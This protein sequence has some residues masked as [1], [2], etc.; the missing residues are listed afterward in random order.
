MTDGKEEKREKLAF[1]LIAMIVLAAFSMRS[2]M[3]CVGPL[4]NELRTDLSLSAAEGGMLTTLPL[5]IFAVTAPVSVT[6]SDR[7]GM[8]RGIAISLSVILL[9]TLLRSIGNAFFLFSGTVL[10]G[11][12]TGFLNVAVPAFFKEYY[13]LSSGKLMG[14]Y[15]S[16]LTLASASTALFIEP[17]Y[18]AFGSWKAAFVT[19]FVFPLGAFLFALP[20][21]KKESPKEKKREEKEKERSESIWCRRNIMI[22]LYMGLQSLIFYTLLT[23]YP[24]IIS[25]TRDISINKGSLITI[26]QVASFFPAYFIPVISTRKNITA[27]SSVIPLL[28][29]PGIAAAYFIFSSVSLVAGT[30]VFGLSI[31]ATF[32]M[33]ITLCSVYGKSG[34][35]TA[36]MMSFGQC[37]GYILASIGPTGFGTLYDITSSWNL[38]VIALMV[39]SVFMTLTALLVR[40]E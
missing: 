40:R 33:G 35:D 31:G 12:G 14:L 17:L 15:S 11:I 29:I 9:G 1:S 30:I 18:S 37:I 39:L 25:S 27:L 16:S 2:P 19:V 34:H 28:F 20:L 38:T 26:M 6:V 23:W 8:K 22:A 32:S 36:K 13:P 21:I 5:L 24:T 3:G 10:I 4:M 7:I